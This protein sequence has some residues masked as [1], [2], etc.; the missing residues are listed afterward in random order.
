[1]AFELN[2]LQLERGHKFLRRPPSNLK[3]ALLSSLYFVNDIFV[4][5]LKYFCRLIL[6]L[7]VW[8]TQKVFF[9]VLN[10]P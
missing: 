10:R 6:S 4:T 1:M 5:K 3:Y 8:K 7:A 9:R 2:E